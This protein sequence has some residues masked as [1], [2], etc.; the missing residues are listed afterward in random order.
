MF[1][2]HALPHAIVRRN[3]MGPAKYRGD[4]P[5]PGM[6]QWSR[7]CYEVE[8][9]RRRIASMEW[10]SPRSVGHYIDLGAAF[11][12]LTLLPA[13]FLLD[14]RTCGQG[15]LNDAGRD[16]EEIKDT[17]L[18]IMRLARELEDD[19]GQTR[20]P[21]PRSCARS[22]QRCPATPHQR[23]GTASSRHQKSPRD[24]KCQ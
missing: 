14:V 16:A 1:N 12:G 22:S 9:E 4:P 11:L 8:P 13:G 10:G 19:R 17:A 20:A 24:A 6:G 23:R 7:Q 2:D 15:G 18:E 3:Y 5:Q 21:L